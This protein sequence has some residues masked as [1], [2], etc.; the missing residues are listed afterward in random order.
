MCWGLLIKDFGPELIYL[1]RVNNDVADCLRRLK[2]DEDDVMPNHFALDKED[3]NAYPLTYKL[4][5]KYQQKDNKLLQESINDKTHSLYIFTTAGHTH[6]LIV[7]NNKIV[8][9]LEP[10]EPVVHWYHKQL[11]HSEQTQTV[12]TV[13]QYF[14]WQ[15]LPTIGEKYAPLVIRVS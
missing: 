8:I 15:G 6:T 14:I 3:V 10:Q 5:M 1:P 7:K 4:I 2:Y 13:C 12:L 11:C 9:P